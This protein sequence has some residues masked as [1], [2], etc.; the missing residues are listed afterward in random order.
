M[1]KETDRIVR[2]LRHEVYEDSTMREAAAAL[3]ERQA[4]RIKRLEGALRELVTKAVIEPN[5]M[6]GQA[7]AAL[8]P[9]PPPN[10]EKDPSP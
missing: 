2:Y 7:R 9:A 8:T 3:I 10:A 4:E 1:T 5:Y 6:V